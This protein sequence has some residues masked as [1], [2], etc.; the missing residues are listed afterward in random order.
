[1]LSFDNHACE[2]ITL[3]RQGRE[4]AHVALSDFQVGFGI[5]EAERMRVVIENLSPDCPVNRALYFH[6]FRLLHAIG[7]LSIADEVIE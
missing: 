5:S 4:I 2:I 3:G 1:L 6:D 7:G